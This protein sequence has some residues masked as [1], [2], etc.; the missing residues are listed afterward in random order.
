[1]SHHTCAAFTNSS[2]ARSEGKN[3]KNRKKNREKQREGRKKVMSARKYENIA[4]SHPESNHPIIKRSK[5]E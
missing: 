4:T 1:V 2:P 3:K 5:K